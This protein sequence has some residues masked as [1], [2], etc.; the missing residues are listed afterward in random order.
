MTEAFDWPRFGGTLTG[1]IPEVQSTEDLLRTRG[2][3][4]AEL[5]GGHG[6]RQA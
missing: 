6:H 2:E 1:S 4:Q 5:F 3:I